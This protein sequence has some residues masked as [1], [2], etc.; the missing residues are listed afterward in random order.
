M[1]RAR[2]ALL[3]MPGDSTR[4]IEKGAG[5][6]VDG[7]IMDLEDGV[8]LSQKAVARE[9]TLQALQSLDFGGSEKLVRINPVKSGLEWDD[10]AVTIEGRPDAYVIPK[11]E[12]PKHIEKISRWLTTEEDKRGWPDGSIRLL[13]IIET[14]VGVVNLRKIARA[15]KRLDAL[16]FGAEDLASS[17]DA[18][19]TPGMSEVAYARGA[20]V[21]HAKAR[22]LQAIDT[23]FVDLQNSDGLADEAKSARQMGFD[24]KLAI[25]PAQVPMI[26]GAFAPSNEEIAQAE[27]LIAAFDAHQQQGTGVFSYDGKMVDMPMIRAAR[28][29]LA[30]SGS[31]QE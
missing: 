10:L 21:I 15:S 19:R 29:V 2:R 9:T 18:V 6:D 22:K 11:V 1:T 8:A 3:F 26:T 20:L 5:L 30:R 16:A 31:S 23:P 25:H 4:K 14:A 7:V 12:R 27:A 28:N 24:G 13:A 17:I